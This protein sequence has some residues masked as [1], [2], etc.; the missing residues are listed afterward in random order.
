[1]SSSAEVDFVHPSNISV[2]E[3][4]D[5]DEDGT[6]IV[7]SDNH[8]VENSE[9]SLISDEEYVSICAP[10]YSPVVSDVSVHTN[11]DEDLNEIDDDEIIPPDTD[12]VVFEASSTE[13]KFPAMPTWPG[14]KLVIDNVDKNI[15]PTFH[16][17]DR[18]TQSVHYCHTIAIKDRIDLSEYSEVSSNNLFNFSGFV[19]NAQDLELIKKDLQILVHRLASVICIP[20]PS[21]C[22]FRRVIVQYIPSFSTEGE[23]VQ[24]HIPSRFSEQMSKKSVVISFHAMEL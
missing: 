23:F 10:P 9:Y 17:I 18:Q 16:R 1:M 13:S 14:F 8:E 6:E 3:P 21:L 15:H 20:N 22:T 5:E 4:L 2:D 19:P 7:E 24:W 12:N 11:S